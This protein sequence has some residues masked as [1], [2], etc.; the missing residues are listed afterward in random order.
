MF[1]LIMLRVI[2]YGIKKNQ[3]IKSKL[4]FLLK[5]PKQLGF[6]GGDHVFFRL[7]L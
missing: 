4:K 5:N 2:E 7:K 3:S 6:C 1:R